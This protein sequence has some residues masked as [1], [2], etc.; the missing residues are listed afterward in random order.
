[1]KNVYT[2]K[3]Q[4]QGQFYK[5]PTAL[6]DNPIYSAMKNDSKL[7]YAVLLD[8]VPLSIKNN[9]VNANNEVI[10][11]MSRKKLMIKL[12]IR[13]T[14]KMT[15]VMKELVD[16]KLI[17]YKRMGLTKCNEIYVYPPDQV[18]PAKQI[19]Q[20]Q[21]F[22]KKGSEAVELSPLAQ[23]QA[24]L[25][26]EKS[27]EKEPQLKTSKQT[28]FQEAPKIITPKPSPTAPDL[29]ASS[30]DF[31]EDLFDNKI[32]VE[33]LKIKYDDSFIDEIC[34]NIRQMFSNITTCI[35][36]QNQ[37]QSVV[38]NVLKNLR[39]YHI[40]HVVDSFRKASLTTKISNTRMYLQ[41]MIYNS[42]CEAK[43]SMINEIQVTHGYC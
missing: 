38:R 30:D 39:M 7:T 22:K 20:P 31:L 15:S 32:H 25:I 9:W 29:V 13:G 23:A 18:V 36:R 14:Q 35:G 4:F 41:T 28:T 11:R 42:I 12:G 10:I 1:M 19:A 2:N 5:I 8:L 24:A 37:P 33:D 43:G 6:L 26:I 3:D 34:H 16:H 17:I 21:D 40:E 27:V